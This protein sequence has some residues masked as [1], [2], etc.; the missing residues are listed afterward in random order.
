M[1]GAWQL[2]YPE[3]ATKTEILGHSLPIYLI[4]VPFFFSIQY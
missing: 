4:H 1:P 3:R 2:S